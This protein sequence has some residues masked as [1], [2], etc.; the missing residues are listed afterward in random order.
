MD[1]LMLPAGGVGEE[2]NGWGGGISISFIIVTLPNTWV[3]VRKERE[4][5]G[6]KNGKEAN[7]VRVGSTRDGACPS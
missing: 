4:R 7:Q 6:E 3:E 2:L 5:G 1:G